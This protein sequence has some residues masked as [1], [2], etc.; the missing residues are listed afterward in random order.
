MGQNTSV[1]THSSSTRREVLFQRP[2]TPRILLEDD[3][4]FGGPLEGLRLGVALDVSMAAW[5]RSAEVST[6]SLDGKL[7]ATNP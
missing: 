1:R 7:A 3:I 5:V 4:G 2:P 6:A